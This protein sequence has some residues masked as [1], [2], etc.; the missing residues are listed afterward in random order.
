M[1]LSK[2]LINQTAYRLKAAVEVRSNGTDAKSAPVKIVA[3]SGDPIFYDGIGL[4]VWDFASMS[5]KS[6]IPLDRDHDG[7]DV[8]GYLNRIDVTA[9]GLV[10]AGAITTGGDQSLNVLVQKIADGAAYEASIESHGGTLEVVG[11]GEVVVVNGRP[12]VGP[13]FVVR[14]WKLAAVA[15]CKFGKDDQTSVS[16]AA[17]KNNSQRQKVT[18]VA[19]SNKGG[20]EVTNT[21]NVEQVAAVEAE[22]APVAEAPVAAEVEAP[23]TDLVDEQKDQAEAVEAVDAV[24]TEVAEVAEVADE[25]AAV[26]ADEPVALAAAVEAPK[27]DVREEFRQFVAAFGADAAD[28]FAAG[29]SMEAAQAKFVLKLKA[30]NADLKTKLASADRGAGEPVKFVDSGSKTASFSDLFKVRK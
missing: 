18:F 3:N 23:K 4:I 16:L 20:M 9:D 22:V 21:D 29:L 7:S 28:F 15:I 11:E 19:S 14:D 24:T 30:E 12:Q 10:C 1:S 5:H 13:L 2:L 27:V 6:R 17:S 25:V 26:E 8:I